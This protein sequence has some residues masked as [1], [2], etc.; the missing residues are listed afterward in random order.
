MDPRNLKNSNGS[1]TPRRIDST[2]CGTRDSRLD[3]RKRGGS[4]D[5]DLERAVGLIEDELFAAQ[6]D[7]NHDAVEE[8]VRAAEELRD[9]L[10]EDEDPELLDRVL[11]SGRQWLGPSDQRVNQ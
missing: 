3:S 6:R 2:D 9:A 4:E 5:D 1:L 11:G 10:T 8:V 7:G